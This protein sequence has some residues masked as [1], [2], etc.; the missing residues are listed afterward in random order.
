MFVKFLKF[1]MRW[2]QRLILIAGL[3]I[4]GI[5]LFFIGREHNIYLDNKSFGE[6]KAFEQVNVKINDGE[7]AELLPRDRDVRKAVGTKFKI[8]AEVFDEDGESVKTITKEIHVDFSRDIMINLP[9]LAG[10]A[11]NFIVPAPR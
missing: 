6:Y 2:F 11:E 8:Y 7:E 4:L 1:L 9:S 3:I 10:G 5:W